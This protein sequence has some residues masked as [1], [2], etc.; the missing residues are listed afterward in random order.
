MEKVLIGLIKE[1]LKTMGLKNVSV[2]VYTKAEE[3]DPKCEIYGS[4]TYIVMSYKSVTYEYW[5]KTAEIL[6][7]TE[8]FDVYRICCEFNQKIVAEAIKLFLEEN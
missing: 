4:K 6:T 1:Q 7:T 8:R 3:D 5:E 2:D